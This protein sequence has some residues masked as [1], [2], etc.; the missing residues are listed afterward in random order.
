M[1]SLKRY[2]TCRWL[3]KWRLAKQNY[4]IRLSIVNKMTINHEPDYENIISHV[5][6]TLNMLASF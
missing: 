3:H 1:V 6:D 4:G 5:N 2:N